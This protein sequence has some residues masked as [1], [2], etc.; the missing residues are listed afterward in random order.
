MAYNGKTAVITGGTGGI[1]MA[2]ARHL[3][4]EG[5]AVR[6][7]KFISIIVFSFSFVFANRTWLFLMFSRTRRNWMR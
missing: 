2:T 5:L 7:G 4:Q 1:G 6:D 3:L